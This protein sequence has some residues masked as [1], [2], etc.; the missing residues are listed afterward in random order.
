MASGYLLWNSQ[1][2]ARESDTIPYLA[3]FGG[4]DM[5]N[6]A[7]TRFEDHVSDSIRAGL[8]KADVIR[9]GAKVRGRA[10]E[11]L[12][13]KERQ[14]AEVLQRHY[15]QM[16]AVIQAQP[17]GAQSGTAHAESTLG[18][19]GGGDFASPPIDPAT[20]AAAADLLQKMSCTQIAPAEAD[21]LL[22]LITEIQ[23]GPRTSK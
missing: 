1:P 4:L 6:Q 21:H 19:F 11:A 13:D 22:A 9:A 16:L 7:A 17:E 10:S 8:A 14:A 2:V 3:S 18:A 12:T 20:L 23:F 5:S 15:R